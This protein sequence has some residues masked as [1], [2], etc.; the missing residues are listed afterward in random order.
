MGPFELMNVTGVPI[1]FH[2]ATTLG[3]RVRADVRIAGAPSRPGGSRQPWTIDGTPDAALFATVG[4]RLA[5]AACYVAGA[6]VD[7][8]VGTI[9]DTDIGARVGLRWRRGPFEL[10]NHLGLA[11]ARD[12]VAAFAARWNV[13]V[14]ATLDN[15][16]RP[17]GRS[18]SRSC[19][20]RS[21]MASPR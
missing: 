11:R 4:D 9:E 15:Q 7:E 18:A 19:V 10:M 21:P 3:R 5:A 2:A 12:L 17:A 1:A 14:P 13:R 20:R 16:A 8:G 6:L